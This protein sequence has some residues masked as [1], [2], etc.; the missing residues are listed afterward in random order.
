MTLYRLGL[1]GSELGDPSAR[2]AYERSLALF[3]QLGDTLGMAVVLNALAVAASAA[4][5]DE[6]ALSYISESLPLARQATDRWDLARL[7]INAGSLWL[8]RGDDRQAQD[9]FGESLRLWSAIGH[10]AGIAHGLA[11]LGGVAAA[12]GQ[13][14]QAGRL[15]GAARKVCPPTD[16]FVS[17]AGGVDLDRRITQARAGLDAAEFEKGW[18]AGQSLP[19][20]AAIGAALDM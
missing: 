1:A 11:G 18:A 3:R 10:M 15:F 14:K 2:A 5:D 8:R 17:A 13:A 16:P 19:L 6:A 4:G 12:R 20:D 9:L 7:L